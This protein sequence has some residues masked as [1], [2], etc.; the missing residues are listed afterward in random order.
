MKRGTS[1]LSLIVGVDKPSGM[2]SHDV[3]NR[4]RT[5]FGERRVGHTGTLDPLATGVLLVAVG[6]ATR[7][8]AYFEHHDKSYRVRIA[9][10]IGTDTDD[11]Q[12]AVVSRAEPPDCLLDES[13]ARARVAALVGRAKQLPPVYSALKVGGKKA[14]DEARAGRVIDLAPRDIEIYRAE[15]LGI[16]APEELHGEHGCVCWDVELHVSKGTYIRSIARDLGLSLSC[17]A[18]VASLRRLSAGR[19]SLDDCV[20]LET[21]EDIG[22]RAALDPIDLLG[23]RFFFAEGDVAEKVSHG[24]ALSA[25]QVEL[26]EKRYPDI[27]SRLCACTSGVQ[28]SCEPAREGETVAVIVG[29]KLAALYSYDDAK[30]A[31]AARCVFQTGVS[32]GEGI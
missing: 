11:A 9:F 6:P 24:S 28:A 5:I 1:G 8:D 18:H 7:L 30:R 27:S 3:V 17:S 31:F 26:C 25:R 32:R 16:S 22:V 13:F 14:C 29:N 15:L 4:V 10:G 19:L 23:M 20:S 21:L 12:G 2:S